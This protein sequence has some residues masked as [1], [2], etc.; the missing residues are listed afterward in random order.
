[1]KHLILP[2]CASLAL[3]ACSGLTGA[4]LASVPAVVASGADAMG[5]PPPNVIASKTFVD[6]K[7]LIV[8]A[9]TV[10][11]SANGFVALIEFG[12]FTPGAENTMRIGNLFDQVRVAINAAQAARTA[13]S[14]SAAL[15]AIEPLMVQIA[16][17]IKGN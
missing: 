3:S 16:S 11:A 5:A 6:E 4:P 7:A 8:L 13:D 17:A 14:Y 9:Q 1:M 10:E 12:K 2:I 15:A